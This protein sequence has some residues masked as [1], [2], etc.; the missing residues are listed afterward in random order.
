M[1]KGKAIEIRMNRANLRM[2]LVQ[3]ADGTYGC[4]L[5]KENYNGRVRGGISFTWVYC[6]KCHHVT[7][8]EARKYF[9][10]HTRAKA[11]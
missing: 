10:K 4:Y 8:D 6:E 9:S 2:A 7:E 5:R 1:T 3:Y 11:K